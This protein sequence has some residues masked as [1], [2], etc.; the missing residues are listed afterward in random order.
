MVLKNQPKPVSLRSGVKYRVS[1]DL[2]CMYCVCEVLW[3][4]MY[5]LMVMFERRNVG[6]KIF[7]T[8]LIHRP[9]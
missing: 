6:I 3:E 5:A 1:A 8:F 9:Y 4:C 2:K 7:F